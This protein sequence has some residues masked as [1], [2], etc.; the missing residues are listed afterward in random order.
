MG[1]DSS[2]IDIAL[3]DIFGTEFAMKVNDELYPG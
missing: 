1:K 3:D 2:D